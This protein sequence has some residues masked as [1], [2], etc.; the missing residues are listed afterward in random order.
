MHPTSHT[1][2][3]PACNHPNVASTYSTFMLIVAPPLSS[4]PHLTSYLPSSSYLP[5]SH[6]P[7]QDCVGPGG[8]CSR[9]LLPP[10][11]RR[12]LRNPPP[13]PPRPSPCPQRRGGR[14]ERLPRVT[15]VPHLGRARDGRAGDAGARARTAGTLADGRDQGT[16]PSPLLQVGCSPTYYFL[17]LPPLHLHLL[18]HVLVSSTLT[19]IA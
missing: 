8:C 6:V 10:P 18:P 7:F 1:S 17:Y 9:H 15:R 5:P 19:I 14:H 16:V 13:Q 11:R 3:H 4:H 2:T 12:S